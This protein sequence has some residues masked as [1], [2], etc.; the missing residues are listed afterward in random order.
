MPARRRTVHGLITVKALL[1]QFA[2]LVPELDGPGAGN[3]LPIVVE[4]VIGVAFPADGFLGDI[5]FP[6]EAFGRTRLAQSL[7]GEFVD[8]GNRHLGPVRRADDVVAE[9]EPHPRPRRDGTGHFAV[10]D[11]GQRADVSAGRARRLGAL[12]RFVMS[13][14]L[15][16]AGPSDNVLS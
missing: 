7:L 15:A 11:I 3:E 10:P 14:S 6:I 5:F 9:P 2:A 1:R 12:V 13:S 8:D 16:G 4:A